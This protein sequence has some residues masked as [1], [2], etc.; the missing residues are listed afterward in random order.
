[1]IYTIVMNQATPQKL[2]VSLF[3]IPENYRAMLAEIAFTATQGGHKTSI[4]SCI[5]EALEN[6]LSLSQDEQAKPSLPKV[7]LSAF[8][9]RT[10]ST[11]KQKII[12][13]AATWQLK[14]S[15]PVSMNAVVN[16]AIL[17]YLQKNIQDYQPLF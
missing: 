15:F 8:T 17:A 16:T 6:Y 5:L 9:V 14:T 3:Q 13:C 12:H 4:N 7:P 10:T 2:T 11:L 1:M